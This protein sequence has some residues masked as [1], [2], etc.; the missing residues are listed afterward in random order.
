MRGCLKAEIPP[1]KKETFS[2]LQSSKM[3]SN[4][5]TLKVRDANGM[6]AAP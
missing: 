5:K 6:P 3:Q 1:K 4:K 2:C